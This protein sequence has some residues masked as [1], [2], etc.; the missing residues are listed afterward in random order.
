MG[1]S[2]LSAICLLPILG[3]IYIWLSDT[4]LKIV[5]DHIKINDHIKIKILLGSKFEIEWPFT[6]C[7]RV[8]ECVGGSVNISWT[9]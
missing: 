8:C 4:T 9:D 2:S 5:D 6:V 1:N 7:I 3:R